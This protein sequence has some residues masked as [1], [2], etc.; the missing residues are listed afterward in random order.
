MD[1]DGD[2]DI[3]VCNDFESPDRIWINDGAGRFRAIAK[4]A[5][6][7]ISASS[8]GV[9]FSDIDRDGDV[10]FFL[11]EMLSREHPR[12]KTQMGMMSVTPVSIGEIDNRPQ[13]MRNTLFLNRGDNTYAEIAQYAGVQASEWSWSPLFLDVDLDGYE[14]L[15]IGTGHYYDAMDTDTRLKLKTMSTSLYEQ[16][17]SEVFAYPRLETPN[18][19]FRRAI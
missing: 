18:F 19:I 17:Q 2:P 4:L 6:R 11:A 3:Y 7:N 15:L 8:M 1:G 16:L 12:R 14:D 13:Y 10:D 5:I 9:D